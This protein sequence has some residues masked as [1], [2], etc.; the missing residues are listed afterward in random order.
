MTFGQLAFV[1]RKRLSLPP[2]RAL[3]LYVAN[4]IL[5]PT[6]A[7]VK[8][9]AEQHADRESGFLYITYMGESTFGK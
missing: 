6:S 3:F 5:A 4:G 1:I 2:E 7:L 9:V 8:E